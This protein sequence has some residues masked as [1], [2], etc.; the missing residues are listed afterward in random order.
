MA[1]APPHG[2]IHVFGD[3]MERIPPA[4][5]EAMDQAKAELDVYMARGLE[6][7]EDKQSLL[8]R[9]GQQYVKQ[10]ESIMSKA[11]FHKGRVAWCYR[12][13]RECPVD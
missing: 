5:V 6:Q 10:C 2:P 12:H 4:A 9:L 8:K 3:V 1:S 11:K 7:G 13:E